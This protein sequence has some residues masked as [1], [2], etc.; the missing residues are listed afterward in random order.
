MAANAALLR[1]IGLIGQ[2]LRLNL[3]PG[4]DVGRQLR[5]ETRRRQ[6]H[7][8]HAKLQF[9]ALGG[10]LQMKIARAD[11]ATG[12]QHAVDHPG[13]I[14][15]IA[16][17]E[18]GKIRI[19]TLFQRRCC[20]GSV[21]SSKNPSNNNLRNCHPERSEESLHNLGRSFADQRFRVGARQDDAANLIKLFSD[22]L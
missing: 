9:Q 1:P 16:R 17:V 8:V 21:S 10:R 12:R 6:Q 20:M 3:Q 5:G 7:A 4:Q 2:K 11:R 13:G 15:R 22:G 18:P 19:P 14:L